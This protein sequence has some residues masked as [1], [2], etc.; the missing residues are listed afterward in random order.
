MNMIRILMGLLVAALLAACGGGGGSSGS[1][2]GVEVPLFTNA[3]E[4]AT[5]PLNGAEVYLVGG[6]RAPYTVSSN[7]RF[8]A[9]AGLSG[10][11][12]TV[13][14]VSEGTANIEVRDALGVT[15]SFE[16][17][18]SDGDDRGLYIT[19]PA[20]L[21]LTPGQTTLSFEARGGVAPYAVFSN[22]TNVVRV[23][24][25][26]NTFTLTGQIIGSAVVT[27]LDNTGVTS[28]TINVS[29]SVS[30][31][32]ALAFSPSAAS[33]NVGDT[34]TVLVSGGTGSYSSAVAANPAIATAT[35]SGSTLTISPKAQGI[36]TVTVRDSAGQTVGITVTVSNP[37]AALRLSPATLS[38]SELYNSPIT[39]SIF[40][41]TAPYRAFVDNQTLA[42]V[43]VSGASVTVG[44]GTQGSRCVAGDSPV[45]ITVIDSLGAA[46]TATMTITDES[47][48]SCVVTNPL[49]TNAGLGFTL[50]AT[51]TRVVTISGGVKFSPA[52]TYQV[53]SSN[54]AAATVSALAGDSFTVTAVAAGSSVITVRDA[55]NTTVTF[56]VTVP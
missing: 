11:K 3:P 18:V 17:S 29:V 25:S 45:E 7:N 49:E 8:I 40:G 1:P 51:Q 54:T 35:L 46:G 16:V 20:A 10:D 41:G 26:G 28:K 39:L 9:V 23:N 37:A 32:T 5:V 52:P 30:P 34:I 53:S 4:D 14:G 22:N 15:A 6:G 36:T 56:T 48:A 44:L 19:A 31:G 38:L 24:Q 42:S 33:G 55:A 27:V 2:G 43:S 13:G 12:I 21:T 47:A 50:V